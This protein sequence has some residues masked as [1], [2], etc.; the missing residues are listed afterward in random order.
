MIAETAIIIYPNP[1]RDMLTAGTT[2]Y[3]EKMNIR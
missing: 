3:D 1:T 2:G